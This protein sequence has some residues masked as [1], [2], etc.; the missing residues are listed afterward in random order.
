MLGRS[1]NLI[2]IVASKMEKRHVPTTHPFE[3]AAEGVGTLNVGGCLFTTTTATLKRFPDT[4]LAAMFSGRSVVTKDKNGAYFIDRDGTHFREILN[5]L[6]GSSAST[7]KLIQQRISFSAV[8]ELKVEADFYG[9]KDYMFPFA[10]AA[11]VV[12]KDDYQNKSTVT[13]GEDQLWYIKPDGAI[14]ELVVTVCDHCGFGCIP[15]WL[16]AGY[17]GFTIGRTISSAQPRPTGKCKSC[18]R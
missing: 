11:P 15:I 8:E 4:M 18:R 7:P 17:P 3:E 12:I 14:S 16:H 1:V 13:Q 2:T 5:F 10:P 6:R 9:I